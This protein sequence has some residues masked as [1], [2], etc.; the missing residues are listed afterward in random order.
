MKLRVLGNLFAVFVFALFSY[1]AAQAQIP[2]AVKDAA[3]KTKD[4]TVDTTKKTVELTKD[5]ADK[6]SDATKKVAG[7]TKDATV[8][9][10]KTTG[11]GLKK[12]GNYSVE[13]VDNVK[14]QA[15][16]GGR[17]LTTTTWDGTKWVTKRAWYATKKAAAVTKDAVSGDQNKQP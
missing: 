17:W 6:T 1:S 2:D 13:L 9:A 10:A 5:A 16:E 3:E 7:K 8:D 12:V 14:G 15:Y 4:V 11:S